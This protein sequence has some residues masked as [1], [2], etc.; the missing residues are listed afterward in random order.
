MRSLYSSRLEVMFAVYSGAGDS[1][2]NTG[3][4]LSWL[5]LRVV[6]FN[7]GSPVDGYL[8]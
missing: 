2:F 6:V 5:T 4:L 8:F 7:S 1:L 3:L